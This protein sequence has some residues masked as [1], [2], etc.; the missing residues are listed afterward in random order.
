MARRP[1]GAARAAC[2][3]RVAC[4]AR[5]RRV[6]SEATRGTC[7]GRGGA[8]GVHAT[9]GTCI[10]RGRRVRSEATRGTCAGRGGACGVHAT[11]GTIF[12][13]GAERAM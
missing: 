4:I 6:R 5:G 2:M 3:P 9:C 11:C 12:G 13:E 8:C 7:A 10:A 1:A